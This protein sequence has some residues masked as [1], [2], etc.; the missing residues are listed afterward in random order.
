MNGVRVMIR[1]RLTTP[2]RLM[3][4]IAT[5]DLRF[6]RLGGDEFAVVVHHADEQSLNATLPSIH[7]AVKTPIHHDGHLLQVDAAIGFALARR[8]APWSADSLLRT[9]DTAMYKNKRQR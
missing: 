8:Q 5:N 2:L 1:L 3:G 6:F 9:A 4:H 7:D